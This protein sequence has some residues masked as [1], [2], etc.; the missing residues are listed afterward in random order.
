MIVTKNAMEDEICPECGGHE[1]FEYLHI[2][3]GYDCPR[4]KGEGWIGP[5]NILKMRRR[6]IDGNTKRKT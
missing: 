6:K 1:R 5:N 4:C 2:D 3:G